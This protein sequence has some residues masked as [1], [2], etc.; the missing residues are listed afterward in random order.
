ME[1]HIKLDIE[2]ENAIARTTLVQGDATTIRQIF[3]NL[4]SNACK[5]AYRKGSVIA[6]IGIDVNDENKKAI[7]R[8]SVTD[9]GVGMDDEDLSKLFQRFSQVNRRVSSEYGGSGLGK[10]RTNRK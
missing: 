8:G 6:R 1:R 2:V 5:F 7:V 10:S 4:L 3:L 9:Q